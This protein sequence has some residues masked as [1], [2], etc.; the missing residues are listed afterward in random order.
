MSISQNAIETVGPS[1]HLREAAGRALGLSPVAR[2]FLLQQFWQRRFK[3][4]GLF[5]CSIIFTVLELLD[6]G[7]IFP[8][9]IILLSPDY[10]DHSRTL[11]AI[12]DTL[13]LGRGFLL[14]A[15]LTATIAILLIGKNVYMIFFSLL[16]V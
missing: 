12:V 7:L 16:Q 2:D 11:S 6:V 14:S 10:L 8:V 15:V 9:L 4:A 5:I 13:G 1:G 3:L